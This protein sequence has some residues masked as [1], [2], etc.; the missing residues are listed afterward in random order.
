MPQFVEACA[1]LTLAVPILEESGAIAAK[2]PLQYC[3]NP[4]ASI[5][6]K[7][8][9]DGDTFEWVAGYA[10]VFFSSSGAWLLKSGANY[11]LE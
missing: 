8:C 2:A 6:G 4:R 10:N 5:V 3:L 7:V 1:R 11:Q 9:D